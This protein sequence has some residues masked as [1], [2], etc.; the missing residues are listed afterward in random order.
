DGPSRRIVL[1]GVRSPMIVDYEES[2]RRCGIEVAAGISAAGP[3]RM[4]MTRDV[5]EEA[6]AGVTHFLP[7]AFSPSR[8]RELAVL[9]REQGLTLAA[10][11]LDPSAS[12]ASTARIGDGSFLNAG[13]VVAGACFVGEGLLLNRTASIGHHCRV[14]DYVSLGPAAT[15]CSSITV[16]DNVLIGAG[17]VVLPGISIGDDAVVAAG[18]LLRTNL[19]RGML[20]AG[21]PA[22]IRELDRSRSLLSVEGEE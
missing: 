22:T 2:C 14:G 10:P 4:L 16:G 13:A 9:G 21:A 5:V 11:L 20:A 6:P 18:S 8:R 17:A 19:P 7:C 15:L 3:S 1:V 12:V